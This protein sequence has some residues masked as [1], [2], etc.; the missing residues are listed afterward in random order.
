M[1][2]KELVVSIAK[3]A[4]LKQK[5]VAA[6]LD[7]FVSTIEDAFNAGERV[8]VRGFGTFKK[9]HRNARQGRIVNTGEVIQVPEKDVLTFKQSSLF[10]SEKKDD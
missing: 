10:N 9:K 3:K 2:K 5:D 7:G 8:E 1:Q 4:H 6:M